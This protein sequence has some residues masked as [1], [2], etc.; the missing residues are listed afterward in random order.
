MTTYTDILK[1]L[2]LTIELHIKLISAK[3]NFQSKTTSYG[4]HLE[5]NGLSTKLSYD[6]PSA[7]V[8]ASPS[9]DWKVTNNNAFMTSLL[10]PVFMTLYETHPKFDMKGTWPKYKVKLGKPQKPKKR[11]LGKQSLHKETIK[12]FKVKAGKAQKLTGKVQKAKTRV[13]GK[14]SLHK[15]TKESSM[16]KL[17]RQRKIR[18]LGKS[19]YK[20]TKKLMYKSV[21][22]QKQKIR[23]LRKQSLD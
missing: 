13:L 1:V 22:V 2:I 7:R 17:R 8:K 21:K 10:T 18:L 14:L 9:K 19:E 5:A 16:L 20:G 11:V 3:N 12:M 23:L 15:V 6:L 4:I